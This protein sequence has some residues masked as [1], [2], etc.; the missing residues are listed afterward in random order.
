MPPPSLS[1]W[2]IE[3]MVK[4]QIYDDILVKL[5]LLEGCKRKAESCEYQTKDV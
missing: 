5:R 1:P 2:N 3:F 4:I